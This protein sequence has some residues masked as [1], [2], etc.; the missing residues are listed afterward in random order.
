MKR[1]PIVGR[2]AGLVPMRNPMLAAPAVIIPR[3]RRTWDIAY[4]YRMPAGFGGDINRTHPF[5][6]EP[7]AVDPT[8]PPTFYGQACILDATTHKIRKVMDADDAL[9]AIY[10]IAARP[11]PIAAPTA[12]G[13]YGAVGIGAATPPTNQPI[14]IL[15]AGYIMV[16][17]AGTPV[18]GGDTYVWADADSGANVQGIFTTTTTAGSTIGPLGAQ[19]TFNGGPDANQV[20]ELAF[21]I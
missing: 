6:V 3:R 7:C 12:S 11:F 5:T 13:S 16:P 10:G 19:S 2:R 15:R 9:T 4:T 17:V 1:I 20:C 8:N 18:K 14:D 21:N